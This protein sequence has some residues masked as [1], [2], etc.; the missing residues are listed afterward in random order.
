MAEAKEHIGINSEN[1]MDYVRVALALETLAYH[2]KEYL[3]SMLRNES[4]FSQEIQWLLS[5]S[6]SISENCKELQA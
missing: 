2:N 6:V 3:N 4:N 5:K 1:P